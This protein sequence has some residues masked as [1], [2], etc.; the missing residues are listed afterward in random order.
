MKTST[1]LVA[2]IIALALTSCKEDAIPKPDGFLSLEYPTATYEAYTEPN[3]F[4]KFNKNKGTVVKS[5]ENFSFKIVYPK[6]KSSI[7]I[8]CCPLNNMLNL[9][10]RDAQKLTYEHIV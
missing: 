10:L 5:D 8:D 4:F 2:A 3:G 6:M 1:F 9:L 7:Y